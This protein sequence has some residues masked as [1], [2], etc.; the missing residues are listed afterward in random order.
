MQ[1]LQ[2]CKLKLL[3]SKIMQSYYISSP[4]PRSDNNETLLCKTSSWNNTEDVSVDVRF[5][6]Q[7]GRTQGLT[8]SYTLDPEVSSV[9]PRQSFMRYLFICSPPPADKVWRANLHQ[10]SPFI[11]L[12]CAKSQWSKLF[13]HIF[14]WNTKIWYAK[15]IWSL[16]STPS[17]FPCS[18]FHSLRSYIVYCLG[19]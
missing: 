11:W 3:Q 8:Y 17:Y 18:S 6:G 1:E 13:P 14:F 7:P 10:E 5:D 12:S 16:S 19:I 9:F 15:S 2:S 4:L